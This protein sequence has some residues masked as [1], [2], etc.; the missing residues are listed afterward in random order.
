MTIFYYLRFETPPNLEGQ[1]TLFIS[2]RSRVAQ[3]YTQ[4]LVSLFVA[5]YVSQGYVGGIRTR[6]YIGLLMY[7]LSV[8]PCYV[9]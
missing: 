2:L 3:L 7:I 8:G 1:V 5:S 4:A 6:L 9:A